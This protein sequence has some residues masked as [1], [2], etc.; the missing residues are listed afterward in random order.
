MGREGSCQKLNGHID[1]VGLKKYREKAVYG[2]WEVEQLANF[3]NPWSGSRR[4]KM[5]NQLM[6]L[7]LGASLIL[8]N[9]G[10]H[11]VELTK[12]WHQDETMAAR[13]WKNK[14]A[15]FPKALYS[16]RTKKM[17][18]PLM[19]LGLGAD[20]IVSNFEKHGVGVAE[21][22]IGIKIKLW[23]LGSGKRAES[24]NPWCGLEDKQNV[25]RTNGAGF[26]SL[27]KFDPLANHGFLEV[28]KI[29]IKIKLWRLEVEQINRPSKYG[30]AGSKK[31]YTIAMLLGVETWLKLISLS[32]YEWCL[33]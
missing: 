2:S 16:S 14:K 3:P 8:N 24:P 31:R 21:V 4:K 27:S 13:K 11:G 32:T 6:A 23:R 33:H 25:T 5:Q 20:L 22:Q 28:A 30:T 15:N 9:L 1:G 12:I 26:G 19:A 17:P 7:G 10:N 18:E 29:G